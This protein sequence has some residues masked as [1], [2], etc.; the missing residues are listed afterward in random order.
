M[1][2]ETLEEKL[3]NK[4]SPLYGMAKMVLAMENNEKAGLKELVIKAAKDAIESKNTIKELLSLIEEEK[5]SL[6]MGGWVTYNFDKLE[7]RP[8]KY[9]KYF[10]HRK[11]GKVHWE[12]WNGS[13]WAYNG[14]VITHWMEIKP[15]KTQK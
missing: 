3:R 12:T 4:L 5:D 1:H 9:G 11:D 14:N 8:L 10:V 7:T 6:K 13:G 15:P 2:K